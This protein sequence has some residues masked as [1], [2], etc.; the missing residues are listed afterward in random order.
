MIVYIRVAR[1]RARLKQ[2]FRAFE[3]AQVNDVEF[4]SLPARTNLSQECLLRRAS[5]SLDKR[6][7]PTDW[8]T[9]CMISSGLS[10]AAAEPHVSGNFSQNP[11]AQI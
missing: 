9:P 4:V 11:S 6:F 1:S 5:R 8:R 2:Q 7:D 3:R 10:L